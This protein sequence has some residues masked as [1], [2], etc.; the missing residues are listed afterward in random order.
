MEK[1]DERIVRYM[2][3][4]K[5]NELLNLRLNPSQVETYKSLNTPDK[6]ITDF[7]HSLEGKSFDE[8]R[9]LINT[10]SK[11]LGLSDDDTIRLFR[12]FEVQGLIQ[13]TSQNLEHIAYRIGTKDN[14][15]IM[16]LIEPKFC[17]VNQDKLTTILKQ[18]EKNTLNLKQTSSG[19]ILKASK[20]IDI[21]GHKVSVCNIDDIPSLAGYF[22]TPQGWGDSLIGHTENDIYR[23]FANFKHVFNKPTNGNPVCYTYGTNGKYPMWGHDSGFFVNVPRGNVH[24]GNTTGLGSSC[25]SLDDCIDMNVSSLSSSVSAKLLSGQSIDDIVNSSIELGKAPEEANLLNGADSGIVLS[26]SH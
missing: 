9:L 20:V 6:V 18:V 10:Q 5:L 22:H 24:A 8:A 11:K 3:K 4:F 21:G 13:K 12:L 26:R 19:E 14:F 15:K 2:G 7:L 25:K 17:S 1:L 16:S 23:R